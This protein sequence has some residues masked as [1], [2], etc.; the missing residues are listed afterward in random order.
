[1]F[2]HLDQHLDQKNQKQLDI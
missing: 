1:M 2:I